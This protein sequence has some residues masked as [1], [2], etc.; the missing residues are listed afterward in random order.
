MTNQKFVFILRWPIKS[1]FLYLDG[2]SK[3]IFEGDI[4]VTPNVVTIVDD[5]KKIV[6]DDMA[7]NDAITSNRW[8]GG[9]IPYTFSSR[10][11]QGTVPLEIS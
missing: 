1:L 8:S 3:S 11:G 10:F 4:V 7:L 6:K 5:M 9:I 2:Q